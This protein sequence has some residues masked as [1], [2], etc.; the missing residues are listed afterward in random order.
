M[1]W[2]S[3]E[4]LQNWSYDLPSSLCWRQAALEA[5][6]VWVGDGGGQGTLKWQGEEKRG[7]REVCL[8]WP[9]YLQPGRGEMKDHMVVSKCF[10]APPLQPHLAMCAATPGALSLGPWYETSRCLWPLLSLPPQWHRENFSKLRY[11]VPFP[12]KM[13]QVPMASTSD[14]DTTFENFVS[15]SHGHLSLSACL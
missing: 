11:G 13:W 2:A 8:S 10:S 3:A 9:L 1:T 6:Q 14:S 7:E 4:R 12:E 5:R 15:H